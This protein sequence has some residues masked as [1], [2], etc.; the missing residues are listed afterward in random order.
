[1][2]F[3]FV[4][5]EICPWV[6]MFPHPA[7]FRFHLTMDTLAFGYILP[8]TGRIRDFHP[9][10]TCAA[11]R[12]KNRSIDFTMFPGFRQ[13]HETAQDVRGTSAL[14]RPERSGDLEPSSPGGARKHK[15]DILP[16]V[17]LCFYRARDGTRTREVF[18]MKPATPNKIKE[19]RTCASGFNWFWTHFGR[20]CVQNYIFIILFIF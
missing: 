3:L 10:E 16:D 5:P 18:P 19:K 11:R 2:W 7:S 12:T 14:R 13:E 20:I 6:S 15:K 8:T 4:R 17:F 1:M 9:L